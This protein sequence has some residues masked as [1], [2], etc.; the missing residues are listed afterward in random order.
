MS[1]YGVFTYTV[2]DKSF[3]LGPKRYQIGNSIRIDEGTARKIIIDNPGVGLTR[4][5]PTRQ[6]LVGGQ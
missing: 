5:K 4:E 2:S 1:P 3:S 6:Q